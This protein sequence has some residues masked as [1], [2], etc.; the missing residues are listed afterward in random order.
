MYVD[1]EAFVCIDLE[2]NMTLMYI[3]DIESF[4]LNIAVVDRSIIVDNIQTQQIQTLVEMI[5]YAY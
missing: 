4:A 5:D 3:E 1:L 2:T